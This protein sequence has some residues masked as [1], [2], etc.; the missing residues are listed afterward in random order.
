MFKLLTYSFF[1]CCC[2]LSNNALSGFETLPEDKRTLC[3]QKLHYP[4]SLGIK[5]QCEAIWDEST[6][7]KSWQQRLSFV[8]GHLTFTEF[9]AI[10][11]HYKKLNKSTTKLSYN[12]QKSYQLIDFLSPALQTLNGSRFVPETS[13]LPENLFHYFFKNERNVISNKLT[14]YMNC[15]GVAYEVLRQPD[16]EISLFIAR[17]QLMSRYIRQQSTL[18][19]QANDVRDASFTQN[20]QPGDV[21]LVLHDNNNVEYLDHAAVVIDKGIFFEKAGSGKNVPI[22]LTDKET[23]SKLWIPKVFHFQLYR[24]NQEALWPKPMQIFNPLESDYTKRFPLLNQMTHQESQRYSFDYGVVDGKLDYGLWFK[25]ETL[26][27]K[28][29]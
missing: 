13:S 21:I 28:V 17:P 7:I 25:V 16:K 29:N 4:E 2:L 20:M 12:K 14:S 19:T 8:F 22:R 26:P 11:N 18:I 3:Q 9:D 5:Y 27:V 6:N 23:F 1:I 10:R 24:P 15:W